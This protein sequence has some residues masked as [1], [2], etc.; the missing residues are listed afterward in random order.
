MTRL[1]AVEWRMNIINCAPSSKC[2]ALVHNAH[3]LVYTYTSHAFQSQ[4]WNEDIYLRRWK[5][6]SFLL[7]LWKMTL[8]F[9]T[10]HCS[11]QSR[12]RMTRRCLLSNNVYFVIEMISQSPQLLLG[13]I[14]KNDLMIW[15]LGWAPS[16]WDENKR[17]WKIN[18]NWI[19]VQ[20]YTDI[21]WDFISSGPELL[22][23]QNAMNSE[24]IDH[25]AHIYSNYLA[26]NGDCTE[27]QDE[28]SVI[29]FSIFNNKLSGLSFET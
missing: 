3:Y 10:T 29:R 27:I 19:V 9:L 22:G 8:N 13:F 12:T 28:W 1:K 6:F 21:F 5:C 18:K 16:C 20:L 24:S 2:D 7:F 23:T 17:Q 11:M 14:K 25:C 26:K 15:T 4:T